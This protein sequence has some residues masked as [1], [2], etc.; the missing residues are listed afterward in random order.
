[1]YKFRGL[2]MYSEFGITISDL[3]LITSFS[4]TSVSSF[5][6]LHYATNLEYLYITGTEEGVTLASTDILDLPS[7]ITTLVLDNVLIASSIDFSSLLSLTS[8]SIINGTPFDMSS[9]SLFP[10]SLTFL[11]LSGCTGFD[12][13]LS[14]LPVLTLNTLIMDDLSIPEGTS[15][16]AFTSLMYLSL[17]NSLSQSLSLLSTANTFPANSL[18]SL[19][20]DNNSISD[21]S[22]LV[23]SGT[24]DSSPSVL[25]YLSFSNN[26]VCD[27]DNTIAD[28]QAYF[29]N[30]DVPVT[31]SFSYSQS[32]PCSESISSDGH[33]ACREIYPT[34]WSLECWDGYYYD[35][36]NGSCVEDISSQ[37]PSNIDEYHKCVLPNDGST[38]PS[39]GCRAAWYGDDCDQLYE[40][41][42]PDANLREFLCDAVGYD[43][44]TTPHCDVSEF[45]LGGI[46]GAIDTSKLSISSLE[47][48]R[49]LLNVSSYNVQNNSI[50]VSSPLSLL[51]QTYNIKLYTSDK[52]LYPMNVSDID[53]MYMLNRLKTISIFGNEKVFDISS[54]YRNV[55]IEDLKISWKDTTHSIYIS[56]CRSESNEEYLAF[57][58]A[59]YPFHDISSSTINTRDYLPNSCPLNASPGD[60]PYSCDPETESEC[61]SIVLNE[62]YNSADKVNEKQCAF[63]AKE[64]ADGEC[65]TVHDDSIRQYLKA[66]CLSESDVEANGIISVGTMRSDLTCSSLS[67]SAI[68][69]DASSSIS[70]LDELTT[71]Q[72]LEYGTLLTSL[73]VDGYDL[74]GDTNS[75]SEYDRLVIQIL[76][77]AVT[78]SNSYGSVDSGLT[79]L[80]ASGCNLSAVSDVL[81]LTPIADGDS[82]TQPFKLTSLDLS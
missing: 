12:Y 20:L 62:V 21:I 23:T 63:I 35:E 53:N 74:S 69:S 13:D 58:K 44:E 3:E 26:L 19:I 17:S 78:Y 64:G 28:L 45:E 49:Y 50:S 48:M 2:Y 33:R 7:S 77:K 31:S 8:L 71:L 46:N 9:S 76:A 4:L 55:G 40:V 60:T 80:S 10:T 75:N 6:G 15:F 82:A 5:Q 65:F 72:G 36:S 51:P 56:L 32:C 70:T 68:V 14:V 57:I 37:C 27:I 38:S 25:T 54:L 1:L 29:T 52:E 43:I 61:P 11:D 39:L 42:I 81:D 30:L 59:I 22:V 41:Y 73:T 24:F 34:L 79:T 67:L 66:Y 16:F 18:T 47:G